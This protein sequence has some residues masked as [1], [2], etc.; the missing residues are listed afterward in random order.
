[1]QSLRDLVNRVMLL[2]ER[3]LLN[4]VLSRSEIKE[5]IIQMNQDQLFDKGINSNGVLL[6]EIGGEYALS[7]IVGNPGKW[8]GKIEL[9]L[10]SQ[11]VTLYNTGEFYDSMQVR[12]GKD[13]FEIVGDPIKDGV[14]L[15]RRWGKEVLGLTDENLQILIERIK[16]EIIPIIKETILRAA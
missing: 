4:E 2:D 16:N 8:K 1:M 9:G 13:E 10:P 15:F 7:T 6:G 5:F 14:S 11:W 3:M 12:M